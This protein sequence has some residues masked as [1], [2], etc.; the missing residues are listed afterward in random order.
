MPLTHFFEIKKETVL[1]MCDNNPIK[2]TEL[3]GLDILNVTIIPQRNN[4]TGLFSICAAE[5]ST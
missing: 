5:A 1:R 3:L 2:I 4:N